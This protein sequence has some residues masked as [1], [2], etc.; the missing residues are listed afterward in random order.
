MD[1][2]EVGRCGLDSSGSGKGLVVDSREHCNKTFGSIKG[3]KFFE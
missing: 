1:L 3:M 2:W